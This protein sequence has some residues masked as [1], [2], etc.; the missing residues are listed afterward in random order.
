MKTP[1]TQLRRVEAL[2][3]L[4]DGVYDGV[5]GGYVVRFT[6][7]GI[8]YEAHT[9]EGIRTPRAKCKITITNGKLSVETVW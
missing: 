9:S 4:P 3:L 7:D 6:V 2:D 5:W 8:D 1:A